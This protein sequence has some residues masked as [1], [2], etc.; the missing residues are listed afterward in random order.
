MDNIDEIKKRIDIVEFIGSYLQLKKA[1]INYSALCPFH[2]EKTSSFMVSSERQSYKC[3]GCSESGDVISFFMKM[4]G[5]S[6]PESL[7]VLGERVG[8]QVELKPKQQLDRE[9]TR[10]D[11]IYN[12]NLLSAKYF[13]AVLWSKEG[14]PALDYLRK[15]GLSDKTIEKFKV[16]FAPPETK[17]AGQLQ[18]HGFSQNDIA[19]SG[20]P[21]RFRYR[22]IFPIFSVL[23]QISG[24]SG[25]ILEDILPQGLSPHPKYLNT[26]ET[27]VFHKS[28]VLYG[29]NFAKD[30]I[31]KNK[32]A[33]IVEGQMD[34]LMSHEAG[35]EEVVATSGTAITEEHLRILGRYT[36]NIIFSFDEDEAGQKAAD[37]AVKI[38]LLN[39]LEVKLTTIEKFKDVGELVQSDGKMWVEVVKRALPPIEWLMIR[40][41]KVNP[42]LS[43]LQKK[44]LAQKALGFISRMQDEI[45]KSHYISYLAK[46][47]AVPVM[48][49]EKALNRMLDKRLNPKKSEKEE[50]K[51]PKDNLEISFLSFVLFYPAIA[52]QTKLN[53]AL[54]FEAEE[55]NK[56]YKEILSCYD[57]KSN[58]KECLEKV[59]NSLSRDQRDSF[60]AEALGWDKKIEEGRDEAIAEFIAIKHLLF[61]KQNEKVKDDFAHRIAEAESSGEIEKVRNLMIELQEN[62]K[63]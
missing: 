12:V 43:A 4:E 34:V 14:R 15:R 10:R 29:I 6:F 40:A 30:A 1:G 18:R 47:L 45:E 46:N 60:G 3:F 31:R 36:P 8:V 37:N 16:G 17:L 27:P 59:Q 5:L 58:I 26:P 35:V 20:H 32:R 33:I 21:E 62:L 22:I 13:K 49:V 51:S 42:E 41:K 19:L 2:T 56:V 38:G 39:S 53:D 55:Y 54:E 28:K 52:S 24:F 57:S 23:G 44:E 63:G 7:K 50:I 48:S 9:K 61:R 25:R 11:V